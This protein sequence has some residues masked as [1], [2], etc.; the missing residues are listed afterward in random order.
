MSIEA[1]AEVKALAGGDVMIA[2][3]VVNEGSIS[4]TG[5]QVVMAAGQKV[6]L[7]VQLV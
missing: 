4:A 2:P 7:L 3:K 1:G 6:Y 5:G